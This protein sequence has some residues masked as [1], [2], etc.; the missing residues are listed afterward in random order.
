VN[1]DGE[2]RDFR[3]GLFLLVVWAVIWQIGEVL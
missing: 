3:F 2:R 1:D